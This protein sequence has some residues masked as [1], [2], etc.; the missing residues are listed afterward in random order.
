MKILDFIVLLLLLGALGFGAYV[1]WLNFPGEPEEYASFVSNF[2][3]I[4]EK[5]TENVNASNTL[6][7]FYP[8]MRYADKNISY[9]L[10][11]ACTSEKWEDIK[12]AFEILS[13]RTILTFY[14]AREKPEIKVLCSEAVMEAE[15]A[16]HFIAGEGGPSEII[17][18]SNY[19]VILNGKI[20]LYRAERC[21]EPKIAIHE[22][23]HALGFDHYNN[24]NSIMYPI[25]GCNQEIDEEIVEDINNLYSTKSLPDLAIE[26]I[27][28]NKTGRYLN[29]DINIS[30]DGLKDSKWAELN[31]YSGNEEIA[32]FT[33]GELEIGMKKMMFVQNVL[34]SGDSDRLEFVIDSKNEGELSLKNNRAEISLA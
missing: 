29:F 30:N 16:G 23:L 34:L 5:Q 2:S 12:S 11:S 14:E 31:I 10:E 27:T 8:N 28:A 19:A 3:G 13:E 17:N 15:E 26:S 32:N 4:I 33:I 25:T 22:I 20:S 21:G 24:T 7:Q 6:V 9:R 18:T 1:F